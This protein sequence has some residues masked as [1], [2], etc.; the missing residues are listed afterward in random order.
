MSFGGDK[1]CKTKKFL[2]NLEAGKQ[3]VWI[4]ERKRSI[5]F[6]LIFTVAFLLYMYKAPVGGYN[7]SG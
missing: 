1:A 5:G 2:F 7:P 6:H 4:M 3:N